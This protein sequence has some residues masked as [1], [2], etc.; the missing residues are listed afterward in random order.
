VAFASTAT[1]NLDTASQ[2]GLPELVDGF[3]TWLATSVVRLAEQAIDQGATDE[4]ARLLAD[5][6]ALFHDQ[7]AIRALEARLA[8]N[9]GADL[10]P[11]RPSD[12]GPG[13]DC[14][15][16]REREVARLVARGLTNGQIADELVISRGTVMV[17]IKHILGR[18][19][20]SSRTQVA[21]WYAQHAGLE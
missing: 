18:L 15:T 10:A 20:M 7:S 1:L 12:A 13:M 3:R 6:R 5:N 11:R 2:L 8:V 14:L 19:G 9:S 21:A 17:H 16:P 4:A